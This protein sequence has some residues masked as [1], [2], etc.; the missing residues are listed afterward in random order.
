MLFKSNV[1]F[2]TSPLLSLTFIAANLPFLVERVLF[3]TRPGNG[4][5]RRRGA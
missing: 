2:S 4:G 3:I 5:K 1:N